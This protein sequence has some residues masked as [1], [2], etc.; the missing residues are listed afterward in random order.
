[1]SGRPLDQDT[2]LALLDP[3]P[4]AAIEKLDRLTQQVRRWLEWKHCPDPQGAVAESLA[5]AVYQPDRLIGMTEGDFRGFIFGIAANVARELRRTHA[6]EQSLDAA[7]WSQWSSGADE[8]QRILDRLT[9]AQIRQCLSPKEFKVLT[10]YAT[11]DDHDRLCRELNVTRDT[12]R[13]RIHRMRQKVRA[14][15]GR[16]GSH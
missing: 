6:R 14:C 5:R 8:E 16:R 3:D 10:R 2:L 13:V 15:L 1:M 9:V 12:L 7:A 4:V 11:W